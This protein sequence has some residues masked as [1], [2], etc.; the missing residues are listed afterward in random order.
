MDY[1]INLTQGQAALSFDKSSGLFNNVFLSLEIKQGSWWIDPTFGLKD[2]G[3]QKNIERVASL[4]KDDIRSALQW[5]LD[6]GRA[7]A[8]DITTQIDR[9]LDRNRLWARVSVTAANGQTVTFDK[10]IEV[11]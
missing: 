2:R 6:T 7:T 5:L 9:Q 8:I 1:T 11:V 10:F 4:I 3:R